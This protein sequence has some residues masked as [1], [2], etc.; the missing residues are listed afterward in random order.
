MTFKKFLKLIKDDRLSPN[1]HFAERD[2][3]EDYFRT[4]TTTINSFKDYR[5]K[6]FWKH[7][8]CQE[9]NE[10]GE[11]LYRFWKKYAKSNQ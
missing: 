11:L 5:N 3:A 6:I 2:F 9:A 8:M 10:A 1:V 4:D 7:R